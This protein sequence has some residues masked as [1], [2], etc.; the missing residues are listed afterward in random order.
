MFT[1]KHANTNLYAL[2]LN[3]ELV[4]SSTRA[5]PCVAAKKYNHI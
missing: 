5:L 2:A 4:T 3:F 1:N